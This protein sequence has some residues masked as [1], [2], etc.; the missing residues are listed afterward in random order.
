MNSLD[1]TPPVVTS[2]VTTSVPAAA[3]PDASEVRSRGGCGLSGFHLH[4]A[5]LVVQAGSRMSSV[6]PCMSAAQ[7]EAPFG[8]LQPVRPNGGC[9]TQASFID[10]R[11]S[12]G[13]ARG[14][15]E[16]RITLQ[17]FP[18]SGGHDQVA[19]APRKALSGQGASPST[20]SAWEAQATLAP[21]LAWPELSTSQLYA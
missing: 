17:G 10:G 1:A 21:K 6:T 9:F 11:G 14:A 18:E 12:T 4:S 16:G 7:G 15:N 19:N 13:V 2:Q 5:H 3:T 20:A 8:R